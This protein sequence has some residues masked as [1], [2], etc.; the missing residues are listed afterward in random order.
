MGVI[1]QNQRAEMFISVEV[2]YGVGRGWTRFRNGNVVAAGNES[3][4]T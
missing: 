1:L 4:E 2:E 3:Q